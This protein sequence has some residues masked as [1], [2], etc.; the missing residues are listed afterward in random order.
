V[1]NGKNVVPNANAMVASNAGTS[2]PPA[3]FFARRKNK[4]HPS[5]D[6]NP[7]VKIV[8]SQTF[9]VITHQ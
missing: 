9:T 3:A 8:V 7:T 6:T 5:A 4:T 1:P 2:F